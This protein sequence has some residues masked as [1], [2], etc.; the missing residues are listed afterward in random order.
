V[1]V[2]EVEESYTISFEYIYSPSCKQTREESKKNCV[3]EVGERVK[4]LDGFRGGAKRKRRRKV[5]QVVFSSLEA[6]CG[7]VP[8][9]CDN[10][11]SEEI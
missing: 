7:L 5:V 10:E 3:C 9:I 6:P 1:K 2:E 8:L 11:T 4:E